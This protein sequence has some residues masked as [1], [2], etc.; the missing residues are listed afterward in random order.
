MYYSLNAEIR[1]NNKQKALVFR[2]SADFKFCLVPYLK[3]FFPENR[4]YGLHEDNITNQFSFIF[5]IVSC[6][7]VYML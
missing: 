7:H 3:L 6:F 5:L 1:T 2:R 4:K